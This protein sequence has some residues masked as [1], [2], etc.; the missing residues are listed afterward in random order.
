MRVGSGVV[1]RGDER[2][3]APAIKAV[4]GSA[5]A[6]G[7]GNELPP[8]LPLAV[9]AQDEG[10]CS[11]GADPE[12]KN[13]GS[14]PPDLKSMTAQLR[15]LPDVDRVGVPGDMLAEADDSKEKAAFHTFHTGT[16]AYGRCVRARRS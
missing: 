5:T 9:S 12:D 2:A 4:E 11:G 3:R 13:P 10:Q 6:L 8:Q 7:T 14:I 15:P 1:V 16:T